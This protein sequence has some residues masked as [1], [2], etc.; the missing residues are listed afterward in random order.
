MRDKGIQSLGKKKKLLND[1]L[2]NISWILE[3]S[4]DRTGWVSS[5]QAGR[6]TEGREERTMVRRVEPSH[7]KARSWW[8]GERVGCRD[9]LFGSGTIMSDDPPEEEDKGVNGGS[10]V[11]VKATGRN[12]LKKLGS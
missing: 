7:R 9:H 1:G 11:G 3:R 6:T 12:A 10:G 8:G 2:W 5:E 4:Q